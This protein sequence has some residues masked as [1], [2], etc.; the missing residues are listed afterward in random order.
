MKLIILIAIA[1]VLYKFWKKLV[2]VDKNYE[3]LIRDDI[4]G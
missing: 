3:E 2:E 4:G 1:M